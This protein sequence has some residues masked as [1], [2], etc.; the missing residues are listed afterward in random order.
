MSHKDSV[1]I[2]VPAAPAKSGRIV[3]AE[4]IE[5]TGVHPSRL[6]ELIELGWIEP[7]VT[8]NKEYLFRLRDVYRLRKFERIMADFELT[9]QGGTIVVDL[10]ERVE[11]LQT[12]VREL[13]DLL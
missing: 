1:S 2:S 13:E 7:I 12:R 9:V 4:F 5:Q 3:W 11:A 8:G 6:G 10:L